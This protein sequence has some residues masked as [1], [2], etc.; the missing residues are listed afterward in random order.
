MFDRRLVINNI[1]AEW[2]H[3]CKLLKRACEKRK[4]G[5]ARKLKH[6]NDLIFLEQKW[7]VS[8][9]SGRCPGIATLVPTRYSKRDRFFMRCGA[10][11]TGFLNP[12][13]P[14]HDLSNDVRLK[15]QESEKHHAKLSL[16]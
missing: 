5:V 4:Y 16:P 11:V 12:F 8:K 6:T 2:K 10:C 9:G 13:E 3:A 7:H 1:A 14:L 15:K